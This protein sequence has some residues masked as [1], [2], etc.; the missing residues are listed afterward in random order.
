[1]LNNPKTM[2]PP[3]SIEENHK[4]YGQQKLVFQICYIFL[5]YESINILQERMNISCVCPWFDINL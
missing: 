1:M 4:K 2:H 5:G 3:I